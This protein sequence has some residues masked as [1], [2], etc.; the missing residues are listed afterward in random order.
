MHK[1][2]PSACCSNLSQY[3]GELEFILCVYLRQVYV[4][5][6]L[7][8]FLREVYVFMCLVYVFMCVS[9]ASLCVKFMCLCV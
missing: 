9:Q 2:D 8:V 6:C 5:M 3:W 7:C 1:W 4:F